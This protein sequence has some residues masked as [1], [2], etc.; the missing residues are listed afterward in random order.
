MQELGIDISSQES[1]TLDRYLD[2]PFDKVITVCDQANEG[3]PVL[4]GARKRLTWSFPDP[5]QATGS[6]E[7]HVAVYRQLRDAVRV[8]ATPCPASPPSYRRSNAERAII[9]IRAPQAVAS[10]PQPANSWSKVSKLVRIHKTAAAA[11]AETPA[12][13]WRCRPRR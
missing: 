11:S 3:C 10:R 6:E 13:R 9:T 1:K 2:Q 7:E 5:S 4:F 8:R 12:R